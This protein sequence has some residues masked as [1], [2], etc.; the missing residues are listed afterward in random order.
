MHLF[1][2]VLS[3]LM[4]LLQAFHRQES[5]IEAPIRWPIFANF[6]KKN[7]FNFIWITFRTFLE[8]IEKTKLL[9][10]EGIKLL[11]ALQHN[12]SALPSLLRCTGT[13]LL[14]PSRTM[15]LPARRIVQA[16]ISKILVALNNPSQ[17]YRVKIFYLLFPFWLQP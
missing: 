5:E 2:G 13:I 9:I 3:K 14:I 4:W 8:P 12:C 6:R 16:G 1:G 17:L 11:H 10:F 7:I 15:C